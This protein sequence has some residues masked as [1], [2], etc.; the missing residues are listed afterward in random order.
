[1]KNLGW[2]I[3]NSCSFNDRSVGAGEP[4]AKP[5]NRSIDC[6]PAARMADRKLSAGD[7]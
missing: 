3:A 5:M 4:V 2:R 6:R 7:G 1:M